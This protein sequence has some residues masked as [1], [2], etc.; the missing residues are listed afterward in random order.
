MILL[1][2]ILP[3]I[4]ALLFVCFDDVYT[5]NACTYKAAEPAPRVYIALGDSVSSGSG[6]DG[7]PASPAERHT[8]IF[9]E[10]LKNKGYVDEY[11]NKAVS[12]FTTT[13]LLEKLHNMNSDELMLFQNANII[14]LNIG[15]N[16]LLTPFLGYLSDLRVAASLNN[17]RTG[18]GSVVSGTWGIISEVLSGVGSFISDTEETGFRLGTIRVRAG[19]IVSGFRELITVACAVVSGTSDIISIWRASLPPELKAMLEE[20]VQTF[21]VEFIE[22]IT[23]LQT[24]APNATLIVNTIHNPIPQEVLRASVPL[25]ALAD[26]LLQSMNDIIISESKSRGY[27][28]VD[29]HS[30]FLNQL[31]LTNFNI[32]PIAGA[33]SFDIVHPNAEGH[34]L[35]AMQHYIRWLEYKGR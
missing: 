34:N 29:L 10:K 8:T 25:S 19:E 33:L 23:W 26:V 14:T 24:N 18:A 35:I 12:G 17:V 30:H 20:G 28:V 6:L 1:K 22:I 7:Y 13:M 21:S 9:F 4:S 32:N 27:L 31:Y 3:F 2:N 15:G 5:E 11:H 16:N